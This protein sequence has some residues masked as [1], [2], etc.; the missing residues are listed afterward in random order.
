MA[1]SAAAQSEY[2]VISISNPGTIAGVV[3]WSGPP[4]HAATFP[5]NKD[6]EICDPAIAQNP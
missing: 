4:P 5:I 3:K 1:G 2:Q 6:P